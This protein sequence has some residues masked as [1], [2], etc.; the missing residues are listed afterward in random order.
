METPSLYLYILYIMYS[1]RLLCSSAK[2]LVKVDGAAYDVVV[3]GHF[4]K[5]SAKKTALCGE[6]LQIVG[7]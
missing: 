7:A 2:C 5:L 1:V 4:V 3:V 6:H